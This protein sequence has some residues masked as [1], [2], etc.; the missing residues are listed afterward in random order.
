MSRTIKCPCGNDVYVMP[1]QEGRK[2]YC[3]RKC[4]CDYRSPIGPRLD[5]RGKRNSPDT[6]F[7]TKEFKKPDS[8][9]YLRYRI[10]GVMTREHRY[11]MEQHLGR[12]LETSEV[13]HHI[14]GDR[15]NNNID[16]LEVMSVGEHTRFHKLGGQY[17]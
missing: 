5:R 11:V 1:H 13:V 4:Q 17:A 8:K 7:K 12:K 9:G 3:S 14:D 2:K 16:N 10:N 15:L 6:E